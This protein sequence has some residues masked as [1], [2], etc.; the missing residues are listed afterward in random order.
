MFR[1]K[2]KLK[3]V[4]S[5]RP[6]TNYVDFVTNILLSLFYHIFTYSSIPLSIHHLYFCT[7]CTFTFFNAFLFFILR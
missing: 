1:H 5:D 3:E 4:Y 7:F 2:E 6:S